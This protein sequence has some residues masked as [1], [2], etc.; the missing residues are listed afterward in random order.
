MKYKSLWFLI[1]AFLTFTLSCAHQEKSNTSS[2]LKEKFLT[3]EMA[4]YRRAQLT[5]VKYELQLDL[6]AGEKSYS[7]EQFV[8]FS[9]RD[10]RDLFIDFQKGEIKSLQ[11]NSVAVPIERGET[12]VKLAKEYL[13]PGENKV[14]ILFTQDYSRDGVGL[15]LFKDPE[16][17]STYLHTQF[18]PFDASRM[19]PFFDQ[20]DLK[21]A[22]KLTVKSPKTWEVISNTKIEQQK[23]SVDYKTTQFY[24]TQ[25]ISTYLF[26]LA[27]GPFT[28]WT[29]TYRSTPLAIYARKSLAKYIPH[30]DWFQITKQGFEFFESYFGITYPFA[31]YDQIVV[32]EFNFGA[33]ENVGAVFFAERYVRRGGY[34]RLDR[35]GFYNTVMHEMA[36]M[37]FGN[38]VTMKWW[39]D[40]W[41]NESF[42]TYMAA[43][44]LSEATEFKE[45]WVEFHGD[46]LWAYHED[47]MV[48][49][50]PISGEVKNTN[51]AFANFDGITYGKGASV[52]KELH[53]YLGEEVF[54]NSLKSYFKKHAYQNTTLSDFIGAFEATTGSDM[55]AWFK[56]WLET[57]GVDTVAQSFVCEGNKTTVQL[58]FSEGARPHALKVA[59]YKAAKSGGLTKTHESEVVFNPSVAKTLTHSLELRN[60][61]ANEGCPDFIYANHDDYAYI[62]IV[63]SESDVNFLK[64]HISQFTDP[65]TRLTLWGNLWQMVRDQKLKIETFSELALSALKTESDFVVLDFIAQKT[66]GLKWGA[67]DSVYYLQSQATDADKKSYLDMTGRYE[68]VL[69]ERMK[70]S[71]GDL[72][73]FFMD[74]YMV[75]V[76]S[77]Q[78]VKNVFGIFTKLKDPDQRWKALSTLCREEYVDIETLLEQELKKDNSD[79]ALKNALACRASR[80]SLNNKKSVLGQLTVEKLNYSSEEVDRLAKS[81]F[82]AKQRELIKNFKE[83]IFQAIETV[84]PKLSENYQYD[85]AA[86][87]APTF[88]DGES[89]KELG[90]LL[91]RNKSLPKSIAKPLLI[92]H[93]DDKRCVAI[94]Q[95]NAR[96]IEVPAA[97]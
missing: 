48:T 6:T 9:V 20:P 24:A 19:A 17:N 59:G 5:N 41:L 11:V 87:L 96:P 12:F 60:V 69:N 27:A 51:E 21:A 37:W 25:P 42:A 29:D 86:G 31:K 95:Y 36:H 35:L 43:V 10:Q 78:G 45:A 32:P 90:E 80:P 23:N 76:N 62:K 38:L 53:L 8:T 77:T 30:K 72:N 50:H 84:W 40:L 73:K 88:C 52:M 47:Q 75:S 46:K 79:R 94:R 44:A 16:D 7:G 54:K 14:L 28:A 97:N 92:K 81:V 15:H 56:A 58:Q 2:F 82:P 49:T 66:V 55:K 22:L 70:K 65:L 13:K 33:M 3:R 83:Q 89:N 91:A 93:D 4:E 68:A 85:L 57:T 67:F 71:T 74:A 39:N 26:A 34:T 18:E 61:T 63:L 1:A 64:T